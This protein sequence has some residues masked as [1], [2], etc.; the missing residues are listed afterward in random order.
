MAAAVERY[1]DFG[2]ITGLQDEG[3]SLGISWRQ[4]QGV[5]HIAEAIFG[6]QDFYLCPGRE[7]AKMVIHS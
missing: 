6:P 4:F 1:L 2:Q 5:K 3:E 7:I